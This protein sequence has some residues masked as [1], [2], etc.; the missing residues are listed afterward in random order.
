[1]ANLYFVALTSVAMLKYRLLEL[2]MVLRSGITYTLLGIFIVG[3]YGAVFALFNFAFQSQSDSSRLLTAIS[4][5]AVVA[6]ALQP[7][8]TQ[9]Q[10]W[11]DRWFYRERYD[12]LQALRQFS[13]ET[14]DI[15]DLNSISHSLTGLVRRAMMSSSASLLLPSPQTSHFYVAS[16][17]GFKP[18]R[19][20]GLRERS[21]DEVLLR[22]D[23]P[24]LV[25]LQENEGI[26]TRSD[27]EVITRFRALT[28]A[29]R[30]VIDALETELLIPL[31]RKGDLTGLLVVGAKL[32]DEGYS[33]NDINLLQT[34]VNQTATAIEN[35]RL[36]ARESER[37]AAVEQLEKLKQTLLLTVSHELKTPLT[38]I[39]AGTEMLAMQEDG[40]A[41]SAHSRLLRSINRGVERLERLVEESL[42]YA[43]MQDSN[44][45]LELQPTDLRKL[46][47]ETV[48]IVM[49]AARAKRQDLE[50]CLPDQVPPVLIDRRRCERVLLNLIS[51]ANRY[52][53]PGGKIRVDVQVEPTYLITSVVD[54]GQGVPADELDKI[55]SVYYRNSTAD[56]KGAGSSS[57]LGLAIAKYLVELHGGRIWVDSKVGVGSSFHYSLPLGVRNESLSYR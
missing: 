35:A 10:V 43:Q 4:A 39:K 41:D 6:I 30:E 37:L 17:S 14:K 19:E 26:L 24:I 23:C 27:L 11:V 42:D 2:R 7:V 33:S 44:L 21:I 36:Y 25:W 32:S 55:F 13:Q 18:D 53:Q 34:V 47:E 9:L 49:P 57:G 48:G 16:A 56:G 1:M 29:D 28:V 52:T 12:H 3:I 31:K 54:T 45:K 8:L 46:Y 51:N 5:A 50:L 22:K 40:P 15:T 38:A 20:R